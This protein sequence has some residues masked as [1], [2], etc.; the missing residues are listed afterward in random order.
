MDSLP[1]L[2]GALLPAWA[3]SRGTQQGWE[4]W[5]LPGYPL[6]VFD[7]S[8]VYSGHV[9]T[10]WVLLHQSCAWLQ[11]RSMKG[12]RKISTL[13][14][15]QHQPCLYPWLRLRRRHLPSQDDANATE[16]MVR[17]MSCRVEKPLCSH[18]KLVAGPSGIC[19]SLEESCRYQQ[20]S[21]LAWSSFRSEAESAL[22]GLTL[23]SQQR[24]HM[25][26]VCLQELSLSRSNLLGHTWSH[27]PPRHE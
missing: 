16:Q 17:L 13:N 12:T 9:H 11:T 18:S 1:G 7:R 5:L 8:A 21:S 2:L 19:F 25:T 3:C 10:G 20:L 4:L 24:R 15:L 26:R 22:L 6:R 27:D 23:V 14:S